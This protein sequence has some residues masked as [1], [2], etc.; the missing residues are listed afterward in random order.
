MERKSEVR[1]TFENKNEALF[2]LFKMENK[3]RQLEVAEGD[4]VYIAFGIAECDKG[5]SIIGRKTL[6][7]K[8]PEDFVV[9]GVEKC[10]DL[11]EEYIKK[12]FY[13]LK[14][15]YTVSV[16]YNTNERESFEDVIQ[17]ELKIAA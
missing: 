10:N 4:E 5:L 6:V 17:S 13:M 16:Q 9:Q 2:E 12:G 7:F 8:T 1:K 11:L 15:R 14:I 3:V